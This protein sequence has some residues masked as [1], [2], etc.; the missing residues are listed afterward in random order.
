VVAVVVAGPEDPSPFGDAHV[1]DF[2]DGKGALEALLAGLG[3]GR[4]GLATAGQPT[5]HPARCASVE[6]AGAPAGILGELH[7]RIAERLDLPQRIALFELDVQTLASHAAA[8]TTYRE[9]PRFPPVR[10]DLAFTL[11]AAIPAGDVRAALEEAGGELLGS[12]VLFDV[13][14]GPPLPQGKKSL[15][16]SVDLRASDRTLTDAEAAEVVAAIETRL[17]ADFRAELRS[18]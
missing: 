17:A 3:V 8:S 4:W 10:R 14:Q 18:A 16:F 1:R 9:I 6:I 15:A 11:D 2:F 13:H 12:A 5:L 7:P